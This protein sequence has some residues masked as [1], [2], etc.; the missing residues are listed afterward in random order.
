MDVLRIGARY[1]ELGLSS[2]AQEALQIDERSV[3]RT[4]CDPPLRQNRRVP[5]V[6]LALAPLEPRLGRTRLARLTQALAMVVGTESMIALEDVVGLDP[7]E[8]KT[9]RCWAID[10]LVAAALRETYAVG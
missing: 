2:M 4:P 5:L 7:G 10:A 6:E 1:G 3:R 8:A 9:V